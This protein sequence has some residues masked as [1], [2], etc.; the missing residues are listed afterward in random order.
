MKETR[1]NIQKVY[2]ETQTKI[3]NEWLEGHNKS[4]CEKKYRDDARNR[5]SIIRN[6]FVCYENIVKIINLLS[7]KKL[8]TSK[9][10][11]QSKNNGNMRIWK[12][13]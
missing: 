11:E 5:N 4:V 1:K 13:Y 6:S 12:Y 2:W 10:S 9:I 3:E 7:K 8:I